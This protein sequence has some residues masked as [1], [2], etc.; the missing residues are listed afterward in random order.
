MDRMLSKR[1]TREFALP[2]ALAV[3]FSAEAFTER[4]NTVVRGGAV[5]MP[6]AVADVLDAAKRW[7]PT[8]LLVTD[9]VFSFDPD[10]F[11]A[12][13]MS[14]G[15]V[16]AIASGEHASEEELRTLVCR[17]LAESALLH[18]REDSLAERAQRISGTRS[19]VRR[20]IAPLRKKLA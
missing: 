19:R 15:A 20:S 14:V 17:A 5:L 2:L 13:A 11:A 16:L 1:P 9:D 18:R 4:V 7:L 8:V 12:L 3:G 10:R 6:V